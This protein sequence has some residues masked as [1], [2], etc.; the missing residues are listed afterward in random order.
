MFKVAIKGT[1]SKVHQRR[2][3]DINGIL[4]PYSAVIHNQHI[5]L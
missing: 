2:I 4:H 3:S 1:L 5:D